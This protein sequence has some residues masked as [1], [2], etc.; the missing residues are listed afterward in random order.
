MSTESRIALH[1][2]VNGEA[3]T[4]APDSTVLDLLHLLEIQ[5]DRVAVEYNRAILKPPEWG[6]TRIAE[7]AQLEIVQFVGGG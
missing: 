1:A 6:Q 3:R 5:P 7:G 4:L 2:T